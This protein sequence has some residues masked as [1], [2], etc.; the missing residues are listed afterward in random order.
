MAA[1]QMHKPENCRN[2]QIVTVTLQKLKPTP[3]VNRTGPTI[4][5]SLRGKDSGTN[6]L[7]A[8]SLCRFLGSA[9]LRINLPEFKSSVFIDWKGEDG[10]LR[11]CRRQDD[12]V[13]D[14]DF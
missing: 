10:N 6:S 5:H 8:K 14:D 9:P 11:N 3:I 7:G 4:F 13:A 12:Q 2:S 1:P